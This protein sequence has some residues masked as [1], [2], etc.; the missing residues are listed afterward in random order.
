MFTTAA[1]SYSLSD[2]FFLWFK[3]REESV[4]RVTKGRC[5]FSLGIDSPQTLVR[6][7]F[8]Y[9]W[10]F[11]FLPSITRGPWLISIMQTPLFGYY[12]RV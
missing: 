7:N 4:I 3:E 9:I 11:E 5:Y 8:L 10:S 12:Y 2:E 1:L 6:K